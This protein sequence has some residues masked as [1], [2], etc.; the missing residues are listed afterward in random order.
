MVL[1]HQAKPPVTSLRVPPSPPSMPAKEAKG[2]AAS[3]PATPPSPPLKSPMASS[4]MAMVVSNPEAIIKAKPIVQIVTGEE[5]LAIFEAERRLAETGLY[6]VLGGQ[7]VRLV[8]VN[9]SMQCEV[10]NSQTLYVVLSEMIEWQRQ[11]PRGEW[12]TCNPPQHL[13][14]TVINTQHRN[15]LRTLQGI[16]HQPYFDADNQPVM[17]PGFN[18]ETGIYASFGDGQYAISGFEKA[19]AQH[20]LTMLKAELSEFEFERPE[21]LA[22]ALCAILTAVIRPGL[23]LAPAFNVNAASSGSGKSYLASLI[24]LFATPLHP[25]VTSYPTSATEAVKVILAMLLEKPPVILFDDMQ[26]DWMPWGA[27]NKALTSQTTTERRLG[28]SSTSTARTNALFLGTGNNKF[29]IKDMRRRVVTIRLAPKCVQRKFDRMPHKHI[30]SH[31]AEYVGYALTIIQAFL[32]H[33]QRDETLTPIGSYDEWSRFCREP[34]I[35][36]DE[37]DPASSLIKQ[38]KDNTDNEALGVFLKL[39]RDLYGDESMMVREV[40][41]DGPKKAKLLE[42]IHELPVTERDAINPHKLGHYLK[43]HRGVRV[44]GLRIEDGYSTERKSWRVL[45]DEE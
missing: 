36:L 22:A 18:P 4:A 6:Y 40:M 24:V 42:I 12:A 16:G 23:P 32:R 45:K 13:I 26:T 27:I 44:N 2:D 3:R 10:V 34:L 1:R 15:H 35:W 28:T 29:P 19:D 37:P 43:D 25:Y 30:A 5:H 21:D 17:T 33:G 9:G 39:W 8:P 20:A 38:V 41:A 31:R 14:N 11:N 7:L